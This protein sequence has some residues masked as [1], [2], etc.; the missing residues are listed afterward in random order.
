MHEEFERC[1]KEHLNNME[2]RGRLYREGLDEKE[3]S[4]RLAE[5][6][7]PVYQSARN[8]GFGNWVMR[9][10]SCLII[11]RSMRNNM[12]YRRFIQI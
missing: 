6:I 8:A 1:A 3:F 7:L 2:I 12:L 5:V 11:M 4:E 9:R 10:I